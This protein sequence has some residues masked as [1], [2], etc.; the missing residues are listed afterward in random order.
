MGHLGA[1]GPKLGMTQIY[2]N[3]NIL[4][5]ISYKYKSLTNMIIKNLKKT[6]KYPD[7][8]GLSENGQKMSFTKMQFTDHKRAHIKGFIW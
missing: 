1:P 7:L 8:V 5:L 4:I 2:K 6:Q 3:E